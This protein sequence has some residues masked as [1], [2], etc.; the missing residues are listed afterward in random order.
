MPTPASVT[1]PTAPAAEARFRS[2]T[3]HESSI[4]KHHPN[5]RLWIGRGL[6]RAEATLLP[7][8]R[9]PPR[10]RAPA[11]AEVRA[12]R[13]CFHCSG[14]VFHCYRKRVSS[15]RRPHFPAFRG[16]FT[17]LVSAEAIVNSLILTMA[18]AP[19]SA[20]FRRGPKLGSPPIL[21][22][23]ACQKF[24]SNSANQHGATAISSGKLST[25]S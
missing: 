12:H 8:R 2:T 18:A 5:L 6:N 21:A 10:G 16:L 25:H 17:R 22:D 7:G 23:R 13:H 19:W 11:T 24:G 15:G 1:A 20:P 9:G 4:H 14:V 3:L